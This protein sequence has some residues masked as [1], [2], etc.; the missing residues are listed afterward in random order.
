MQR[1]KYYVSGYTAAVLGRLVLF[2]LLVIAVSMGVSFGLQAFLGKEGAG[3]VGNLLGVIVQPVA[4]L[5]LGNLYRELKARK[6]TAPA[7]P[8][9]APLAA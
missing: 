5:F 3:M 4:A 6:E 1:S 8:A 2:G 7:M 9:E